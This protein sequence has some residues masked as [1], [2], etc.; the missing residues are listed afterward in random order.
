GAAT[1]VGLFALAAAALS[2]LGG[3]LARHLACA[4]VVLLRT[5][6]WL[7]AAVPWALVHVPAPGPV[8]M[9]AWLLAA[10]LAA[11][12]SARWARRAAL[13]VAAAGLAGAPRALPRARGGGV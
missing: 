10:V 8:A 4:L 11:T 3:S 7:A 6:G 1:M 2:E 12:V 9:A 13:L 5:A